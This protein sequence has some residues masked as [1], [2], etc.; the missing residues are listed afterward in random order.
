MVLKDDAFGTIVAAVAEGRTIFRNIRAFVLYL[1]SCNLSEILVVGLASLINA[2]LAILPLQILFLNLVTDV[3]PALALGVGEGDQATMKQPPRDPQ[4][5]ILTR[6]HW[7]AVGGYGIVITLAVLGAFALAFVCFA[8]G[9]RQAVT[10][11]FLTLAVAQLAH[12]GLD[13]RASSGT[14]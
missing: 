11:S 9:E 1:M 4:E 2:P 14:R 8:M 3:F 10:V 12:A 13:H 7:L 6:G 5:P